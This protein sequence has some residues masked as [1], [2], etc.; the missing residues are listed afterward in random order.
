MSQSSNPTHTHDNAF[1]KGSTVAAVVKQISFSFLGVGITWICIL[2][3]KAG[4]RPSFVKSSI[5]SS[6]P[7]Q[8]ERG[9]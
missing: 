1:A 7:L 5:F 3:A 2:K 4:A 6:L 9:S 8:I